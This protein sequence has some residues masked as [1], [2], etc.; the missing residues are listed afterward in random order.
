VA[1]VEGPRA[2][3]E[4]VAFE[5][6]QALGEGE[7]RKE[8]HLRAGEPFLLPDYLRD[9][10]ALR[11]LYRR[12]GFV[13]ASIRSR[14]EQRE[15]RVRVVFEVEEG[16]PALVGR[17]RIEGARVTEESLIRR[18]LTFRE[19][20]PLQAAAL[21]E[22]QR[23][24][25]DLGV[26]R[27]AEVRAEPE[28]PGARE[29]QVVVEVSETPDLDLNYGL[30]YNTE[31][32]FEGLA[33]VRFPNLFGRALALGVTGRINPKQSTILA[34]FHTPFFARYKLD[35][36]LFLGRE[37]DEDELTTSRVTRF[38]F[39][40]SRE[41]ATK[42]RLQWSYGF[43]RIYTLGKVTAASPFPFSFTTDRA[44]LVASLI[45]DRRD[46]VLAP[47]RGRFW[48]VS[49]EYA[50]SLLGSDIKFQKFFGQFFYYYSLRPDLVWASGYRIGLAQGFGQSLLKQDRFQAGGSTTVR[51]FARNSLGPVDPVTDTVI[52]GEAVLVL[53]QELRFP[54]YRWFRGVA[55]YDAGNTFASVDTLRL[56]DLRHNLGVGLRLSFPF[57]LL[58]LDWAR[59]LD[60]RPDEKT[61]R[62]FFSLGHAF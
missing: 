43:R 42:L 4:E 56:G 35:T 11:A 7:V 54:L 33:E 27:S 58:R 24:L 3:L 41:L 13:D 8:L 55:F 20:E 48:S 2:H 57:G 36:D 38:T 52:G 49:F 1:I 30:R 45:G 39:Q 53:N 26:F 16:E 59:V 5:G 47:A 14:I 9:R 21:T 10:A 32:R 31:D 18:Q 25:Y 40:Q 29:R 28:E 60:P 6:L 62:F 44:S 61:S 15:D 46:N 34:S 23:Q 50:P 37:A 17:V 51:G 19:G 22:S 12:R